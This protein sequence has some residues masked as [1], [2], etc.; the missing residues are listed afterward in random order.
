MNHEDR[1]D[2]A[3]KLTERLLGKYGDGILLGGIY[4]STAKGSDTKYSDL[5]MFFIIKNV[6]VI[7]RR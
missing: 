4:G 3:G 2:L 7:F 6:I 1:V 5:E